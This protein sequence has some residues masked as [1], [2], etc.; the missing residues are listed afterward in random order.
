MF[1]LTTIMLTATT[2]MFT[3]SSF[4][5]QKPK[6][7]SDDD[8]DR[9]FAGEFD[10][11]A[12]L[13]EHDLRAADPLDRAVGG[14]PTRR[15]AGGRH[16]RGAG[17][18]GV[19]DGPPGRRTARA[20]RHRGPAGEPAGRDRLLGAFPG[21]RPVRRTVD[22]PRRAQTAGSRAAGVGAPAGDAAARASR[23]GFVSGR[24]RGSGGAPSPRVPA[25]DRG[26]PATGLDGPRQRR[27]PAREPGPHGPRSTRARRCTAVAEAGEVR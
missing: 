15:A 11:D 22:L 21:F 24:P 8:G 2:C 18:A 7:V 17:R 23:P 16:L 20:A 5:T 12:L 6:E 10:R 3:V 26:Q 25:G 9:V 13:A 4:L 27:P 19:G 1:T 14:F